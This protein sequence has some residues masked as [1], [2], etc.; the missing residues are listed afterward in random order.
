MTPPTSNRDDPNDS[1][2]D[3]IHLAVL[4]AMAGWVASTR[5]SFVAAIR[6]TV[7]HRSA[8]DAAWDEY[9]RLHQPTDDPE[10]APWD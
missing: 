10:D 6:N 4:G 5:Q 8:L 7:A 3:T 9:N 2:D 1:W